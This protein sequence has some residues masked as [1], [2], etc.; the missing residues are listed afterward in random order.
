[1]NGWFFLTSI[2][3]VVVYLIYLV[4][5]QLHES[6]RTIFNNYFCIVL[7][8]DW[9]W[10]KV[11][12]IL[13]YFLIV[14][15]SLWSIYVFKNLESGVVEYVIAVEM[16]LTSTFY[17]VVVGIL[18]Y[19]NWIMYWE[20][21]LTQISKTDYLLAT[22]LSVALVVFIGMT[23]EL[24]WFMLISLFFLGVGS[25]V[26]FVLMSLLPV[27]RKRQWKELPQKSSDWFEMTI[28]GIFSFDKRENSEMKSPDLCIPINSDY[29]G[30]WVLMG[31]LDLDGDLELVSTRNHL[32]HDYHDVT[33]ICAQKD[34]GTVLWTWGEANQGVE[35]RSYDVA[36]QIHDL[37]EEGKLEV[38]LAS[39]GYVY[40]LDGLTGAELGKFKI[41]IDECDMLMFLDVSGKGRKTDIL[42]KDR[43][44]QLWVYDWK[45]NLIYTLKNPGGYMLAHAPV[46]ADFDGDGKDEL[47]TGF[48][49]V[50]H[51]GTIIW[52]H[53]SPRVKLWF[54]GH[55]DS[56]FVTKQ[57][58]ANGAETRILLT[59]CDGAGMAMLDGHGN[60]IWELTGVHYATVRTGKLS[61]KLEGKQ[62]IVDLGHLD[63][64]STGE[65]WILNQEG[66]HLATLTGSHRAYPVDWDGDGIDELVGIPTY[67][68][69]RNTGGIAPFAMAR[70][71]YRFKLLDSG[72][73][74]Q[75][76]VLK[77]DGGLALIYRNPSSIKEPR[78]SILNATGI[79]SSSY[80]AT[81]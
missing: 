76:D 66:Q 50:D 47:L 68:G 4:L 30:E 67:Q 46:A 1:M 65:I 80:K 48:S 43:Y 13:T 14:F 69:I 56:V 22:L 36:C 58:N 73:K 64:N 70:D 72:C 10:V 33:S 54:G 59:Y 78:K 51:D 81:I 53:H 62:I 38:V 39:K 32:R 63:K 20:L 44:H 52:T 5:Y 60:L 23:M 35:S 41:E 75:S 77:I 21:T 61:S 17:L 74:G 42:V 11:I 6:I 34:D 28:D 16:I 55:A 49:M 71:F 18:V 2:S 12:K 45:G 19:E 29:G 15:N 37:E 9:H 57:V 7:G 26:L 40:R 3:S 8:K 27:V 79:N 31:D 24:T 25:T